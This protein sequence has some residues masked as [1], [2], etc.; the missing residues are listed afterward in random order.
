MKNNIHE[1]SESSDYKDFK[2][3]SFREY[4]YNIIKKSTLSKRT[5]ED[6]KDKVQALIAENGGDKFFGKMFYIT[7]TELEKDID[8]ACE[9]LF[10]DYEYEGMK[11]QDENAS[12]FST[13]VSGISLTD[14]EIAAAIGF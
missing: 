6:T 4:L 7:L 2:F 11:P 13:F 8:I 14:G 12:K 10:Y 9:D 3:K 1:I 5:K